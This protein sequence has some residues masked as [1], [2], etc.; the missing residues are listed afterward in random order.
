[1]PC[2]WASMACHIGPAGSEPLL[3]QFRL[4][5]CGAL[6]MLF[7]APAL[8]RCVWAAALVCGVVLGIALAIVRLREEL[9]H[10]ITFVGVCQMLFD[11]AFVFLP[12]CF[13]RGEAQFAAQGLTSVVHAAVC[14]LLSTAD[15][16]VWLPTVPLWS[17]GS[18]PMEL[19]AVSCLSTLGTLGLL[20]LV[21]PWLQ[22]DSARAGDRHRDPRRRETDGVNPKQMAWVLSCAVPTIYAPFLCWTLAKKVPDATSTWQRVHTIF[23]ANAFRCGTISLYW[24][25]V[26]VRLLS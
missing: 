14:V 8:N 1:M 4:S 18:L 19:L 22:I 13:T 5:L 25:A 21:W 24:L 9:F 20:W 10:W 2:L 6:V 7:G 23:A 12:R 16:H 17:A 11:A 15:K 26:L 3:L